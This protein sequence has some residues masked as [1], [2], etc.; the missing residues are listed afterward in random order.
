MNDQLYNLLVRSFDAVLDEIDYAQL[1]QALSE[2]ENKVEYDRL[3]ALRKMIKGTAA[4]AF[5]PF[6]V[7][8]LLQRLASAHEEFRR[9]LFQD[10]RR[11]ALVG[12]IIALLLAC[13]N[14]SKHDSISLEAVFAQPE[15][16]LEQVLRLE[17]P[18]E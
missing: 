9:W 16:T 12:G 10:F 3:V 13:Y 6:F 7:Q 2:P 8:R 1:E 18:F 5:K 14:V 17:V 15:Y 11:V 4:S